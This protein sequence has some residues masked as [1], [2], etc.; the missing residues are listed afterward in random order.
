MSSIRVI[1]SAGRD[2]WRGSDI[3]SRQSFPATGNFDLE[4]NAFG[5]LMVHNDDVVAPGEGFDMHQHD[6]VEILTW[7]VDGSLRHRDSGSTGSTELGAGCAQHISAGAGVRHSE[8][9]A[10]GYTSRSSVRVVQS[11]LPADNRDTTPFHASHDY[12]G[13]LAGGGLVQ[14]AGPGSPLPLGTAG[15]A[16][17]AAR[18]DPEVV[19]PAG[20]FV[21]LY[22]IRGHIAVAGENLGEG[23]TLRA[24]DAGELTVDGEGEILVWVMDREL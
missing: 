12:H 23:D 21:H 9:N 6:N 19:V 18:P 13:A 11:W 10:A 20:A 17:Y 5:L 24:T 8:V 4:A 22:V 7:V 15:A 3:L 1:R 14:I 16:L 2:I